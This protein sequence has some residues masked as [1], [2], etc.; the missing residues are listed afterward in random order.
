MRP[1]VGRSPVTPQRADG[2]RIDPLVSLPIEK[3]TSPAAV[4]AAGPA[5]EPLDPSARFHGFLVCPPNHR[6]PC[7]SSPVVSF[8]ISTAPASRRISTTLA[9]SAITWSVYAPEPQVVL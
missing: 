5:D 1:K 4:A 8:A 9:S 3:P 7:A 2:L 6:S